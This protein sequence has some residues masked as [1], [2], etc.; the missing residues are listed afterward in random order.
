VP[1][2]FFCH[3]ERS[4]T[5]TCTQQS[6]SLRARR[7]SLPINTVNFTYTP[8]MLLDS[9]V[10]TST[11]LN[12][13][14]YDAAGRLTQHVLGNGLTQNYTYND[15]DTQGGRLDTL[16]TGTLQDLTY[17]YDNAGNILSIVDDVNG[18]QTQSFAYDTLQRLTNASA[19][20]T[21]FWKFTTMQ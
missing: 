15:W 21:L 20:T 18:P 5:C 12:S 14:R 6:L 16:A 17:S 13:S 3:A 2:V 10:G 8:Q 9:V 4:N 1:I 7:G 19:T 11:Y